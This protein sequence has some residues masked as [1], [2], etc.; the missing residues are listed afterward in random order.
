M[1]KCC[2]LFFCVLFL[3]GQLYSSSSCI[4]I[5]GG[6]TFLRQG[7]FSGDLYEFQGSYIYQGVQHVYGGVTF[8]L[9]KGSICSSHREKC[10]LDIDTQ[11]R[12]GY[13]FG[14]QDRKWIISLFTGLGYRY[15]NI[16]ETWFDISFS[17]T[18]NDLYVP[19]GIFVEGAIGS[20]LR[21]GLLGQWKP[22]V[23]PALSISSREGVQ[24]LQE[25]KLRNFLVE[26]PLAVK[27]C[28]NYP[29][30]LTLKPFLDFWQEGKSLS[31]TKVGLPIPEQSFLFV[32]I[33][34]S[35]STYF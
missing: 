11:E 28:S 15:L 31:N 27:L 19:V 20:R 22:Q 5:G 3:T 26:T 32:G 14:R 6:Y 13:T 23:Y 35:I 10:I 34:A 21:L 1:I 4:D 24:L 9:Q 25:R 18:H 12:L 29:L 2:S 33:N 30:Y 7:S 8:K 16:Q 17:S